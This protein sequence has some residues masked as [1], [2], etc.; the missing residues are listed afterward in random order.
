MALSQQVVSRLRDVGFTTYVHRQAPTNDGGIA[1]G[2][3]AIAQHQENDVRWGA[4]E[5]V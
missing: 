3:L 1:L 2:Q 5:D 4:V